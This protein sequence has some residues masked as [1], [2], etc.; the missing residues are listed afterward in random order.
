MVYSGDDRYTG[1]A[2]TVTLRVVA[3]T[4]KTKVS[5][6]SSTIRVG[7]KVRLTT[8]VTSSTGVTPDG[9]VRIVATN[10]KSTIVRTVRLGAGGKVVVN[11]GPLTRKGTY[12]IAATY[13][14]STTVSGSTSSTIKVKVVR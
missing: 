8:R 13:R 14:A 4:S 10:G 9:T 1:S 12:R 7:K 2:T 11:L 6:A 5:A 3:A